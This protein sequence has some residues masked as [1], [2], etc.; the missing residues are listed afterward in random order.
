MN[1][2]QYTQQNTANLSQAEKDALGISSPDSPTSAPTEAGGKIYTRDELYAMVDPET[3]MRFSIPFLNP[4]DATYHEQ[5]ISAMQIRMRDPLTFAKM[6][7][8]D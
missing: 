3:G 5:Y 6:L 7:R 1:F 4:A 2:D 8:G